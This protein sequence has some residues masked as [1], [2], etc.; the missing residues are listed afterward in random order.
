MLV[1]FVEF[2]NCWD[3]ESK[4]M[5][6][7]HNCIFDQI[8]MSKVDWDCENHDW[9]FRKSTCHLFYSLGIDIFY[10]ALI[11]FDL[12]WGRRKLDYRS[13][14]PLCDNKRCLIFEVFT[15]IKRLCRI[16]SKEIE[17]QIFI[18]FHR[19][20]VSPCFVFFSKWNFQVWTYE[21]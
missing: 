21:I 19:M 5:S 10:S 9:L 3:I 2:I 18:L 11:F 15:R 12:L 14:S 8:F 4:M 1:S 13:K 17:S 20:S 6:R 16:M 7:M